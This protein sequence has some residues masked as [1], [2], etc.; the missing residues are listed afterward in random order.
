MLPS[1]EPSVPQQTG[2]RSVSRLQ[3]TWPVSFPNCRGVPLHIERVNM[4]VHK[5]TFWCYMWVSL[6]C[7]PT[8]P[9]HPFPL[10]KTVTNHLIIHLKDRACAAG[11]KT[12]RKGHRQRHVDG[13][14]QKQ[15][16]SQGIKRG[17]WDEMWRRDVLHF[18]VQDW[19]QTN[20]APDFRNSAKAELQHWDCFIRNLYCLN[21]MWFH[22]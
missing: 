14:H 13:N 8:L 7:T 21:C 6:L 3:C 18:D 17:S 10:N 1:Y 16:S 15:T 4:Q 19:P 22:S 5:D 12:L 2:P 20:S 11:D 9:P